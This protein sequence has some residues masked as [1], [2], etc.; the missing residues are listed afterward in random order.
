MDNERE[1]VQLQQSTVVLSKKQLKE[2]LCFTGRHGHMW[3][4]VCSAYQIWKNEASH[5]QTSVFLLHLK[6]MRP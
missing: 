4:D 5:E 3:A 1:R 2:V 6:F